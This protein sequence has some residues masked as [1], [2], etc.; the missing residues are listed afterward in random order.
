MESKRVSFRGSFDLND[1]GITTAIVF[2][3]LEHRNLAISREKRGDRFR[4][5]IFR[6][7]DVIGTHCHT[8][9]PSDFPC[10]WEVYQMWT[11]ERGCMIYIFVVIV[12][13]LHLSQFSASSA[14]VLY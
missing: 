13:F 4:K 12:T 14:I 2:R 6:T 3:F 11:T 7:C 9:F 5:R 1:H 10:S 8:C